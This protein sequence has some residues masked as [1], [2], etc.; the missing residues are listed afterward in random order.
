MGAPAN[1][2]GYR[3]NESPQHFVSVEE[4]FMGRYQVT[5]KQWLEIM[6]KLPPTDAE[7]LGDEYPVVNV[8]LEL[9]LEFCSKL[10]KQFER[11]YRLPSEAEW[12]YACRAGTTS[13]FAYGPNI[14]ADVANF[15][16][17]NHF[18]SKK[19]AGKTTPVGYFG[20]PNAFGLYD[21][22]GN[23]WE[24]CSDI[25]HSDYNNAP[26][27]G[28]AWVEGGDSSYGVQRGG[29]WRDRANNCRS[30]FR[31][32]D[33]AHNSENIVGLRVCFSP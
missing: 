25:W 12:E 28:T 17:E 2:I 31:V 26:T 10:S 4:F 7:F 13:A 18:S 27:D 15:N 9:A 23:V 8:W 30:A 1:E 5:Q 33:I 6:E 20:N 11:S 29:S 32:G 3:Q 16:N 14:T 22:H 24:W 21:M 19:I